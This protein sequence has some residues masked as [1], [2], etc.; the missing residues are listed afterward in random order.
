MRSIESEWALAACT[1]ALSKTSLLLVK[2]T[3]FCLIKRMIFLSCFPAPK[4]P[5]TL[6]IGNQCGWQAVSLC[7]GIVER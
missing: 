4:Q 6:K 5:S 2:L 1:L 3:V 7:K